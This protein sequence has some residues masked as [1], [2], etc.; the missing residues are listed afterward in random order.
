[1]QTYLRGQDIAMGWSEGRVTYKGKYGFKEGLPASCWACI[2]SLWNCSCGICKCRVSGYRP[3]DGRSLW[4]LSWLN[5][6]ISLILASGLMLGSQ[7]CKAGFDMHAYH[8]AMQ[9][10]GAESSSYRRLPVR[11]PWEDPSAAFQY[12]DLWFVQRRPWNLYSTASAHSAPW[13]THYLIE[14][15]SISQQSVPNHLVS[16]LYGTVWIS[17]VEQVYCCYTSSSGWPE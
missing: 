15:W 13:L 2:V 8:Q 7:L 17:F 1:M 5:A 6:P 14:H 12:E 10:E 9:K 4:M 11:L 3:I 16:E